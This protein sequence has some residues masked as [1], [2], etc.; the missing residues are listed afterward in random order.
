M[1]DYS[2][3]S[4]PPLASFD[5][6]PPP[7]SRFPGS[8]S[9][10]PSSLL[11][12][13]LPLAF[14]PPSLP[15]CSLPY[16]HPSSFPTL[17]PS[18]FLPSSP[19]CYILPSVPHCRAGD[20]F[21]DRS[22]WLPAGATSCAAEMMMMMMIIIPRAEWRCVYQLRVSIMS[23]Y[24]T[25]NMKLKVFCQMDDFHSSLSINQSIDLRRQLLLSVCRP[26]DHYAR[27]RLDGQQGAAAAARTVYVH[28]S[29]QGGHRRPRGA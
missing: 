17:F 12:S 6:P 3:A 25:V 19:W 15:S 20:G 8:L 29:D 13:P 9:P 27:R 11:L 4:F 14:L 7:L 24:C 1:A 5:P 26:S 21:C 18:P 16:P 23:V 10:P 28:G 22:F 2:L